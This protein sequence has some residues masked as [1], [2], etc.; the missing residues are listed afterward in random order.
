MDSELHKNPLYMSDFEALLNIS[1]VEKLRSKISLL[2][3]LS[4]P[5]Y[6]EIHI[7]DRCNSAC[8]FCNQRKFRDN[9]SEMPFETFVDLVTTCKQNG[10]KGVRFSGGGEPSIHP[11]I[12]EMVEFISEIGLVITRFDTNGINLSEKLSQLLIQAGLLVLHISLQAPTEAS[13]SKITGVRASLFHQ[14]LTNIESFLSQEK[15]ETVK[16][17]IS[18]ILD[19]TTIKEIDQISALCNKLNVEIT[20]HGLNGDH[21]SESFINLFDRSLREKLP[22]WS[23]GFKP[24]SLKIKTGEKVPNIDLYGINDLPQDFNQEVTR[25]LCLAPWAG[26]LVKA[27]GD[28]YICCAIQGETVGNIKC[29]GILNVWRGDSYA[30]VR[31]EATQLFLTDGNNSIENIRHHIRYLAKECVG[32]CMVKNGIFYHT[33]LELAFRQIK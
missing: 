18:V 5:L 27:N 21:Y 9:G 4:G 15:A 3:Q 33:D 19:E 26:T 31:G 6:L 20:V 24:S 22:I 7:T 17:Y 13:W 32:E 10:L 28:V 8:Y 30:A 23:Y 16:V 2:G 14:V 12:Y 1:T 25:K 29:G 11:N